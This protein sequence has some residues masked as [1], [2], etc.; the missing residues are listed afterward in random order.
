[1]AHTGCS[2]S[3]AITSRWMLLESV[4]GVDVGLDRQAHT[5]GRN[6]RVRHIELDARRLLESPIA[7]VAHDAD[8]GQPGLRALTASSFEALSNRVF[9]RPEG[10]RHRLVDDRNRLPGAAVALVEH[11]A[12]EQRHPHGLEVAERDD[13]LIGFRCS[14]IVGEGG[15]VDGRRT[16]SARARQGNAV[17]GPDFRDAWQPG[18]A[19]QHLLVEIP[20]LIGLRIPH[21]RNDDSHGENAGRIEPG[22]DRLKPH[23]ALDE[24]T[25]ADQQQQ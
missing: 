12:T 17:A 10:S 14:S 5:R 18:H 21:R 19:P 6:L 16:G 24:Q 25:R 8:D 4:R 13:S 15:V 9:V 11:P 2:R 20:H 23:E 7:H 1:M 3:T 22:V